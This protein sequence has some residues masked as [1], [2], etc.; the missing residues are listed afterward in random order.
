LFAC[1]FALLAS[2]LE[3]RT[4][5]VVG[6]K[7]KDYFQLQQLLELKSSH[8]N[9]WRSTPVSNFVFRVLTGNVQNVEAPPSPPPSPTQ[10]A[11]GGSRGSGGESEKQ[12][13][14]DPTMDL[15]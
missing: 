7:K 8:T 2:L 10:M 12:L 13:L 1:C 4:D 11:D 6:A 9:Y 15:D 14:Q 5:F 3:D